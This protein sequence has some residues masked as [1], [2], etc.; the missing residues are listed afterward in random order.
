MTRCILYLDYKKHVKVM[1][2]SAGWE[3]GNGI[4]I[5][6]GRAPYRCPWGPAPDECRVGIPPIGRRLLPS[7]LGSCVGKACGRACGPV[8][9][10]EDGSVP[11]G[12][13]AP[14]PHLGAAVRACVLVCVRVWGGV[15]KSRYDAFWDFSD[16]LVC[17]ESG[18]RGRLKFLHNSPMLLGIF[19][20]KGTA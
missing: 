11:A 4:K 2:F 9:T 17:A 16:S 7:S 8:V 14:V 19:K 18:Q 15:R 6:W 3:G 20:I 10:P 12:V 13:R 1:C 5:G